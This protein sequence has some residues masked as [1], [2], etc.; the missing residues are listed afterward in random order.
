[1][2]DSRLQRE[3]VQARGGDACSRRVPGHASIFAAQQCRPASARGASFDW[4]CLQSR[5]GNEACRLRPW[6]PSCY[7]RKSHARQRR[8]PPRRD[9]FANFVP[10]PHYAVTR[11]AA[12]FLAAAALLLLAE[13]C[14]LAGHCARHRRLCTFVSGVICIV[15]GLLMLIGLVMYISIFKAEI[16]SKLRP[17][18]QLQPPLFT[19]RYGFSFLLVVSGFMASETAGTCAVFLYIFWHQLEWGRKRHDLH[20]KLSASSALL[21]NKMYDGDQ[22]WCSTL[23]VVTLLCLKFSLQ[24]VP[25]TSVF[26]H[27]QQRRVQVIPHRRYM[28]ESGRGLGGGS[29]SRLPPPEDHCRSPPPPPPCLSR[30]H[31]DLRSAGGCFHAPVPAPHRY[32]AHVDDDCGPTPPPPPTLHHHGH[33]HHHHHHHHQRELSTSSRSSSFFPRDATTNTVST[34][35]DINSCAGDEDDAEGS[36]TPGVVCTAAGP[37]GV[38]TDDDDDDEYSPSLQHEFVTFDLDDTQPQLQPAPQRVMVDEQQQTT[39]SALRPRGDFGF[40]TLR[41][42]TPV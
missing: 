36:G 22:S 20:R 28:L 23:I 12:F 21:L 31:Q 34:T 24:T 3:G 6:P 17:R 7:L 25:F 8:R 39:V 40:D 15:A 26:L 33:H 4:R 18:S 14:V 13:V 38:S 16:G 29:T 1:M 32:H 5:A 35:A 10:P 27:S 30:S 2:E 19:Y 37:N 9:N 42:T 11:S 41:R